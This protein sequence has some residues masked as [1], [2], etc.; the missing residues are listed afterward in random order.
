MGR[1]IFKQCLTLKYQKLF[2]ESSAFR[3]APGSRR[4]G[5]RVQRSAAIFFGLASRAAMKL[6]ADARRKPMPDLAA[7]MAIGDDVRERT[8]R[9]ILKLRDSCDRL[10]RLADPPRDRRLECR[11]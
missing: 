1:T 8:C 11:P 7:L 2:L 9:S 5:R 6:R 4:Y 3:S 10:A